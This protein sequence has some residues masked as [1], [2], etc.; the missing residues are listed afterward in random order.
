MQLIV[1]KSWKKNLILKAIFLC[2]LN[3]SLLVL[4]LLYYSTLGPFL[5]SFRNTTL[6]DNRKYIF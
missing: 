4:R 6:V 3:I 2:Y 1:G 5:W